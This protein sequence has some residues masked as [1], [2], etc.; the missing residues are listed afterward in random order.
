MDGKDEPARNGEE[1]NGPARSDIG[2]NIAHSKYTGFQI[3]RILHKFSFNINY[4]CNK[5][6]KCYNWGL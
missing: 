3:Y 2:K 6:R 5:F 4:L 1:S